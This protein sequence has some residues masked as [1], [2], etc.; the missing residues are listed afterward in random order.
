LKDNIM[1]TAINSNVAT[2]TASH[3][4]N[5]S[6][7]PTHPGSGRAVFAC[8]NETWDEIFAFAD[9]RGF[10]NETMSFMLEEWLKTKQMH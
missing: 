1:S 9:A 2:A 4:V 7:I 8:K 5:A 10:Q 3:V 6:R